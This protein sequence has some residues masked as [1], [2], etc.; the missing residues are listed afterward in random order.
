MKQRY[1]SD[2]GRL[3]S[4]KRIRQLRKT[5]KSW[6][7]ALEI[8]VGDAPAQGNLVGDFG[9]DRRAEPRISIKLKC[10]GQRCKLAE[11]RGDGSGEVVVA[12][13]ED[14]GHVSELAEL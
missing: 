10:G 11:L 14:S 2:M 1:A 13:E 9:W 4:H 6:S 12:E 8:T 7:T 3:K 5:H